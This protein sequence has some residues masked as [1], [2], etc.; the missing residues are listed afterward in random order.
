M[1][2]TGAQLIAMLTLTLLLGMFGFI[3]PEKRLNIINI[4]ILL[5]CLSGIIGGYIAANFY[6]FWGEL[7]G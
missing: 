5:Y 1:L 4:G 6:R 7:T 3:N 2:G